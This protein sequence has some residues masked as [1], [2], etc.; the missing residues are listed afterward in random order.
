MNTESDPNPENQPEGGS[1]SFY[2][3]A[4]DE[5]KEAASTV[6]DAIRE[7]ADE[8]KKVAK[9]VVPALKNTFGKLGYGAAYGTSFVGNFGVALVKELVPNTMR[10]G[11]ADGAEA[12][13]DAATKMTTPKEKSAATDEPIDGVDADYAVT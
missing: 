7:G 6:A 10:D 1:K 4:A 9:E 13:K 2:D 12:G 8:A 5:A 11:F 3:T